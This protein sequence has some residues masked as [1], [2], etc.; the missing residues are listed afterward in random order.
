MV[1]KTGIYVLADM[2]ELMEALS[3]SLED[4]GYL[5]E[6]RVDRSGAS[7]PDQGTTI[8]LVPWT[9]KWV[10]LH[11]DDDRDWISEIVDGVSEGPLDTH[12]IH[13]YYDPDGG[14]YSYTSFRSGKMVEMFSSG[15]TGL[16][17]ILFRSEL[18]KVPIGSIM[19]ARKFM[20]ESVTML[21]L[22]PLPDEPEIKK[23]AWISFSPPEKGSFLRSLLGA[24]KK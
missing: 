20:V 12:I 1:Y 8:S 21:G 6:Q 3:S 4:L 18:R 16:G 14:E 10:R 11:F 9:D 13:C 22:D 2:A 7:P 15:G 23:K 17:T 5:V 24:V 19:D